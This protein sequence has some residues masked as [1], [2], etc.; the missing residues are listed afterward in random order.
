MKEISRSILMRI[1]KLSFNQ[2]IFDSAKIKYENVLRT[3]EYQ[4]K[5]DDLR[6]I[7]KSVHDKSDRQ[8]IAKKV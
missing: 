3:S 6:Y 2:P 5:E 4:I 8:T 7:N 1:N